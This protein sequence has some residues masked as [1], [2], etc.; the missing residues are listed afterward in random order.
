MASWSCFCSC[1]RAR[2][3]ENARV[4]SVLALASFVLGVGFGLNALVETAPGYAAAIVVWTIG[5]ILFT[6]A[7]TSLVA[8]LAPA[9]LRGRYQGAFAAVFTAAF[10]AAPAVGGYLI[11]HAGARWLWIACFATGVA[12]AVGFSMLGRVGPE[13]QRHVDSTA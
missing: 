8:D 13:A 12:V 1:S 6:P 7:S 11:V 4:R 10:A 5:E 3:C 2:S 9:H